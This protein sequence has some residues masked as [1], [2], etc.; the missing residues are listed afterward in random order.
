MTDQEVDLLADT[1]AAEQAS[2]AANASAAEIVLAAA[3]QQEDG[4]IN[5]SNEQENNNSD[6]LDQSG[7]VPAVTTTAP[8]NNEHTETISQVTPATDQNDLENGVDGDEYLIDD[9]Q[10]NV[11]ADV[12]VEEDSELAAIKERVRQMEQEAE[13]LKE[14]QQEVEQA[15]NPGLMTPESVGQL[16]HSNAPPPLAFPSLEEK[17]D[18]DARSIY[19]GQ[20]EY[21]ATAEEV[22]AHFRGCGG[23]NRVTIICDKFSGQPK[24]FGYIEFADKESVE[25]AMALDGSLLKGRS[26][27]VM[28]KRTNKPGITLSDRAKARGR[29]RGRG[30]GGM[31]GGMRGGPGGPMRGRGG[32]RGAFNSGGGFPY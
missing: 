1:T 6:L 8:V 28:P 4:E 26:I 27:K 15:M 20:V 21:T 7:D 9:N 10:R 29:G 13:R 24:G 32:I 12:S 11:S 31:R 25:T 18:A 5:T 14:M 22:E 19:V 3:F 23:V 17:I 16:N 2:S 30:R